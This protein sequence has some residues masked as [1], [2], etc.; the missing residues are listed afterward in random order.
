MAAKAAPDRFGIGYAHRGGTLRHD[1]AT[2]LLQSGAT[3]WE[4]GQFLWHKNHDTTRIYGEW[5]A[6]TVTRHGSTA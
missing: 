6:A 4:I 1:L 3:P 5:Q 2:E